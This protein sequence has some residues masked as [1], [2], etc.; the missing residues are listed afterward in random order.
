[1]PQAAIQG[2]ING[3]AEYK[4]RMAAR[5]SPLPNFTASRL[6]MPLPTSAGSDRGS[7]GSS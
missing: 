3:A 4:L 1:M 5:V 7:G 6:R 2:S